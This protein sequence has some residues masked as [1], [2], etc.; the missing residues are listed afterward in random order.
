MRQT[1][2]PPAK[3]KLRRT[4]HKVKAIS[5]SPVSRTINGSH[6][7]GHDLPQIWCILSEQ[8]ANLVHQPCSTCDDALPDAMD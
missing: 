5:R 2:S 6:T 3:T 4:M 7:F 8:T 1:Y